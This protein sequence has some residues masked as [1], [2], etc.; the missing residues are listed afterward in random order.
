MELRK[1]VLYE[2]HLALGA[3]GHMVAFAGYL[4]PL[5]YSSIHSEHMAV[6]QTTGL[7]D[8][9][10]MSIV[11]VSGYDAKSFLNI[12]TTNE[13]TLLSPGKAQYSYILDTNGNVLDDV[14]IYRCQNDR[15]MVVIN[16]SNELKIKQWLDS[17]YS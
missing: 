10:H 14:V 13:L 17:P 6:R 3:S 9:T 12:V 8:C 11:E 2:N 4:M 7:F 5:W 16:A 1:T 15:F